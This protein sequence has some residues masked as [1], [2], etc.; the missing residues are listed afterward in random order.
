MS[1]CVSSCVSECVC[2]YLMSQNG[3]KKRISF[4]VSHSSWTTHFYHLSL[5][6]NTFVPSITPCQPVFVHLTLH[7]ILFSTICHLMSTRFYNLSLLVNPFSTICSVRFKNNWCDNADSIYLLIFTFT[8]NPKV[9]SLPLSACD[10][11][12]S[13][14]EKNMYS[15]GKN[16]ARL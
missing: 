13:P 8:L 10:H 2:V 4:Q 5:H 3:K 14:D 11:L 9:R 6:D 12:C 15:P 7:D 1:V 16:K